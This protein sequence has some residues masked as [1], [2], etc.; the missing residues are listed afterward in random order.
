M[1]RQK[2]KKNIGTL[3]INFDTPAMDNFSIDEKPDTKI[4]LIQTIQTTL[5]ESSDPD[6][7]VLDDISWIHFQKS[8]DKL[9]ET[10]FLA[11]VQWVK[12][13]DPK[14]EKYFPH[15]RDLL[16]YVPHTPHTNSN[17][18]SRTKTLHERKIILDPKTRSS[19]TSQCITLICQKIL[20]DIPHVSYEKGIFYYSPEGYRRGG[21]SVA[22]EEIIQT[23]PNAT[24]DIFK[25]WENN[26]VQWKLDILKRAEIREKIY[27]FMQKLEILFSENNIAWINIIEN[28]E[29]LC[30]EHNDKKHTESIS[31]FI[32]IPDDDIVEAV[33]TRQHEIISPDP[34]R[35]IGWWGIVSTANRETIDVYAKPAPTIISSDKNTTAEILPDSNQ[36]DIVKKISARYPDIYFLKTGKLDLSKMKVENDFPTTLELLEKIL[37]KKYPF[38]NEHLPEHQHLYTLVDDVFSSRVDNELLEKIQT[39]EETF[40]SFFDDVD[41][42]ISLAEL[43][44]D[45]TKQKE[46]LLTTIV[47]SMYFMY[48]IE[49]GVSPKFSRSHFEDW[50]TEQFFS[51]NRNFKVILPIVRDI[52]KKQTPQTTKLLIEEPYTLE[53][54]RAYKLNK[55]TERPLV[56][57]QGKILREN[58]LAVEMPEVFKQ[59]TSDKSPRHGDIIKTAGKADFPLTL[60]KYWLRITVD[61]IKSMIDFS[62]GRDSTDILKQLFS[63]AWLEE[64]LHEIEQQKNNIVDFCEY[65]ELWIRELGY[66]EILDG[67][68]SDE[69]WDMLHYCFDMISHGL[70]MLLGEEDFLLWFATQYGEQHPHAET[71]WNIVQ[72]MWKNRVDSSV[73]EIAHIVPMFA[74]FMTKRDGEGLVSTFKRNAAADYLKSIAPKVATQNYRRLSS[75]KADTNRAISPEMIARDKKMKERQNIA[76]TI[77]YA[78]RL[79]TYL[80]DHDIQWMII[81]SKMWI[82]Q[83][84]QSWATMPLSKLF[85]MSED[86]WVT[87]I[88]RFLEEDVVEAL[89]LAEKENYVEITETI[90]NEIADTIND[91]GVD[92]LIL[93][94]D[95]KKLSYKWKTVSLQDI[96][97]EKTYDIN[98]RMWLAD[99]DGTRDTVAKIISIDNQTAIDELPKDEAASEEPNRRSS[100]FSDDGDDDLPF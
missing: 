16:R 7:L 65:A 61:E 35:S 26:K 76:T 83:H 57:L 13:N 94:R 99:I 67:I 51:E 10:R 2:E 64:K 71:I 23:V 97:I 84:T 5:D 42:T 86:D 36:S 55:K 79:A 82:L 24:E 32:D 75:T 95:D 69:Y 87:I 81:S 92:E 15:K 73:A 20:P 96:A 54:F 9:W 17:T 72:N 1:A 34:I 38:N 56:R 60:K 80:R 52:L 50:F 30:L 49:D 40:V 33:R 53:M 78:D 12:N 14:F 45:D 21:F 8:I 85:D 91:L 37:K 89:L 90:I 19:Q 74:S 6:S 43:R 22:K 47:V 77:N 59:Y 46:S 98:I 100:P 4:E 58:L 66:S 3:E 27:A 39:H 41:R 18:K 31:K 62:R 88:D 70:Q 48:G 28:K 11:I 25:R 68:K 93:L 29:L 63:E 44:F